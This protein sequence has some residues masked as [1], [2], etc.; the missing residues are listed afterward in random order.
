M[1][2]T[3]NRAPQSCTKRTRSLPCALFPSY[4]HPRCADPFLVSHQ[5]VLAAVTRHRTESSSLYALD[6]N[7][8]PLEAWTS[9][10]GSLEGLQWHF[11]ATDA[12]LRERERDV[13]GVMEDESASYSGSMVVR[14]GVVDESNPKA[15]HG[16]MK[17][18]MA[19]L[20]EFL[21]AA[22]E[23]RLLFLRS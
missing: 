23:E 11:D 16:E 19:Q 14:G 3:L 18:Q 4:V 17:K 7:V 12:L 5:I 21:F 9:R 20:A 13:G 8:L 2:A 10:P 22:F 1:E 15:V 6:P